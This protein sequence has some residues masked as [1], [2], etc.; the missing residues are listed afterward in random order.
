MF[1]KQSQRNSHPLTWRRKRCDGGDACNIVPV[2][3]TNIKPQQVRDTQWLDKKEKQELE[4]LEDDFADDRFLEQYRC[5]VGQYTSSLMHT[6]ST[7]TPH[8][9]TQAKANR[10]A[11]KCSQPAATLWL[12]AG[13]TPQRVCGASHQRGGGRLGGCAAVQ[14]QVCISRLCILCIYTQTHGATTQC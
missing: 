3:T 12:I 5:V 11:E 9:H 4:E 7:T 6:S 14:G 2:A 1:Q 8:V 13:D 10:R